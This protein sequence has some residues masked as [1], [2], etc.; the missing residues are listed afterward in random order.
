MVK[1]ITGLLMLLLPVFLVAAIP[2]GVNSAAKFNERGK[3]WVLEN[4]GTQTV[5]YATGAKKS[6]GGFRSGHRTGS[7]KYYYETGAIKGEGEYSGNLKQGIWKLYH[8]N[9]K[10]ESTGAFRND[11]RTGTWVFFDTDGKKSGEGEYRAGMKEGPWVFYYGSGQVSSKGSYRAGE[12]NGFWEY[13]FQRGQPFQS[14]NFQSDVR[15]GTWNVCV[16]PAGPC[17]KEVYN[18]GLT[19]GAPRVSGLNPAQLPSQDIKAGRNNPGAFL[20]SMEGEVP[21]KVPSSLKGSWND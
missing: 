19:S 9:G 11:A 2:P 1:L 16:G 17:G 6:E 3:V 21:D 18:S 10:V 13:F 5:W 14:G 7:W 12:A 20:D 8:K 15:I 4:G